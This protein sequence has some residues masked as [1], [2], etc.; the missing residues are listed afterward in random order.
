MSNYYASYCDQ[1]ACLCIRLCV[2]L[3]VRMLQ[4]ITHPYFN[5]I[6]VHVAV[7]LARSFS[8]DSATRYVL[9]VL[10]MTSCMHEMS[11]QRL[12]KGKVFP[13]SLPSVGPGADPGVQAVSPQVT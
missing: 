8:D 6:F 2:R 4:R 7:A 9:P 1:R 10:W 11:R 3:C 12:K 13:Y 5:K